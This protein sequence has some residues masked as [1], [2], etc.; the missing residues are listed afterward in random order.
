MERQEQLPGAKGAW[1]RQHFPALSGPARAAAQA[2]RAAAQ[3]VNRRG[4]AAWS[5]AAPSRSSVSFIAP[6]GRPG[7]LRGRG[8]AGRR[9]T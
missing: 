6:S 9:P 1:G 7:P 4:G 2:A 8:S 3:A 5:R